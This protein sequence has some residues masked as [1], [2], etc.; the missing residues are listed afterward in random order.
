MITRKKKILLVQSFLLFSGIILL[1][2]TYL[3]FDQSSSSK[4]LQKDIKIEIDKKIK[5]KN[6]P[7]N[8]FYDIEYSG[9]DLSGNRYI[10]K[11]KEASNRENMEGL[12]DLK[13]V[14]AIFYFKNNTNL[15]INSE[16]GVY[17]NKTLDMIFT[18]NVNGKYGDGILMAGKAEYLNSKNLL[19]ITENVK[20][21]DL[22]GTIQADKL[23]FDINNNTLDISSLEN[24]NVNA[25]L[26]YK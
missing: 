24:N 18:K 12:L 14:K 1:L 9:I 6:N 25:N 16:A 8:I 23:F 13:F 22:K 7:G 17:N 15:I 11:A 20:V 2:V 5:T 21:N 10:L 4:I 19:I 26:K 3:K